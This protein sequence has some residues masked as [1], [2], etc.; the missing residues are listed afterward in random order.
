MIKSFQLFKVI[1]LDPTKLVI[2]FPFSSKY[3]IKFYPETSAL[4]YFY[5]LIFS[6]LFFR[7]LGN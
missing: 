5:S 2:F 4:S 1:H 7:Y 3:L 6:V